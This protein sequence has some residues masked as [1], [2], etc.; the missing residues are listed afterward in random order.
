MALPDTHVIP[1]SGC[2]VPPEIQP[3]RTPGQVFP[4]SVKGQVI[5][6][7]LFPLVAGRLH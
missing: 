7:A 3:A 6:P 4:R 2:S 5:T 1:G